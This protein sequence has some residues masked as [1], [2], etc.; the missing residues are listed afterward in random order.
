MLILASNLSLLTLAGSS[1][2]FPETAMA[3]AGTITIEQEIKGLGR[4][5]DFTTYLRAAAQFAVAIIIILAAIYIAIG[6]YVYFVAAGN[7]AMAAKGKEIIQRSIIGLLI[8]LVAYVI[9]NTISP[10]FVELKPPQLENQ[11]GGGR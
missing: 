9:L 6:A 7:A 3:G 10:Q 4:Q 5:A 2:L 8:A 11:Q 1:L